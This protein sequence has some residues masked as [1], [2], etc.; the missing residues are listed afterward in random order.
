VSAAFT[1]PNVR[2]AWL[3]LGNTTVQ[4]ENP[5]GGWFCENLDL[6]LP[7]VRA[8]TATKPDAD[9]TIDRTQ[10]FGDRAVTIAVHALVGAGARI[11]AVAAMFA[12]FMVPSA[13]P[14]L[15]FVLDRPGV[16]ERTVTLRPAGFS[17]PIVG[18]SERNIQL[19]FVAPDPA[20]YDPTVRNVPAWS[21]SGLAGGRTYP[22]APPR[23]YPAGAAGPSTGVIHSNG[24]LPVRPLLRFYGPVTAPVATIAVPG[25]P[26]V[27]YTVGFLSTFTLAANQY[28]D[29]DTA[30]KT[31]Y[32]NGDPTQ[33][34]LG[35]LNWAPL[36]WPV[37]PV[38]VDNTLAMG[39]S[40]T[41]GVTQVQAIW[42]DKYLT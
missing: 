30:A 20:I 4:L 23:S 24:D 35:Q 39:G 16:A 10:Y 12:P 9:G 13:R 8:V 36:T 14:V 2:R 34:V 40:S 31:A 28:V 19:Q 7:T 17:W 41:S 22:L 21:G 38:G 6:G 5:P 1:Y 15:H 3:V 33:P 42:Q 18:N 27:T 29:V 25:I 37:L 32:V 26:G 11:D